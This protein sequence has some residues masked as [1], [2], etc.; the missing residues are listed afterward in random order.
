[1]LLSIFFYFSFFKVPIL[2]KFGVFPIFFIKH[3]FWTDFWNLNLKMIILH[4]CTFN[5]SKNSIQ[6]IWLNYHTTSWM[7]SQAVLNITDGDLLIWASTNSLHVQRPFLVGLMG[8]KPWVEFVTVSF[9]ITPY[10]LCAWPLC[11]QEFTPYF[12][13]EKKWTR[14]VV[15]I[16]RVLLK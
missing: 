13:H 5:V 10:P 11:Q 9:T 1:M 16:P 4:D 3:I 2:I 14:P 12:I 8:N 6:S 7:H 15:A